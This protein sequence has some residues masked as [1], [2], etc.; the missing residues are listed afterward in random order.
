[1][2]SIPNIIT[3]NNCQILLQGV[4][5]RNIPIHID[6]RKLR[7]CKSFISN[8]HKI[9]DDCLVLSL[10]ISKEDKSS[11]KLTRWENDISIRFNGIFWKL[12]QT[13]KGGITHDNSIPEFRIPLPPSYCRKLF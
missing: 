9:Q 1:M 13:Q 6:F 8:I 2:L 12:T 11:V 10:P 5:Q 7:L 3:Y 4:Q